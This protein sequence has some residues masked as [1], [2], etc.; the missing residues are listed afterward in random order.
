MG[1]LDEGRQQQGGGTKV[2]KVSTTAEGI[3]IDLS[4]V[5]TQTEAQELIAQTLMKQGLVNGSKTFQEAQ[6]KAWQ[7]NNI[8]SLPIK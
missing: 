8:S 6:T 5:R 4:G 1:V 2:P 7:D 3:V